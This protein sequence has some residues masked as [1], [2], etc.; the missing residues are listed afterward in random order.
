[1]KK[2]IVNWFALVGSYP[3]YPIGAV[4]AALEQSG[5]T[6]VSEQHAYG[7]PVV[8]TFKATSMRKAKQHAKLVAAV[9]RKHKVKISFA[10]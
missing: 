5:A 3:F 10:A 8:V 1:M 7:Q 9:C 4:K 6:E 2:Y